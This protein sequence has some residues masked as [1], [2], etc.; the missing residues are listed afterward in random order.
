MELEEIVE[1]AKRGDASAFDR[2]V[3]AHRDMVLGYAR[4]LVRNEQTAE[5]AVQESLVIAHRGLGG[6][7]DSAAFGA[8]LRGIVRRRCVRARGQGTVSLEG[9]EVTDGE[10]ATH[11]IFERI[12]REQIARALGGL[13]PVQHEVVSLYYRD[14]LSQAEIGKRLGLSKATVNMRLHAARARLKRRLVM[15]DDDMRTPKVGRIEQVDGRLV[16]LRFPRDQVPFHFERLDAGGDALRSVRCLPDGLVQAAAVKSNVIW[17]VG[18]EVQ[19]MGEPYLEPLDD[20]VAASI[21]MGTR[22]AGPELMTGIKTI[23]V[24]APLTQGGSVGVFAEWGLGSLVLLPELAKRLD[25]GANRQ[26][27]YA[28]MRPI[29]DEKQWREVNAELAAGSQKIEILYLPIADP[30]AASFVQSLQGLGSKLVLSRSLAEQGIWPCIDPIRSTSTRQS[31]IADEVRKLISGYFS[32]QFGFAERSLDHADWLTVR[33]G[34]LAT[35]FLSQPFHVAEP[36]TRHPGVDADASVAVKTFAGILSG[37]FDD[38][39]KDAFTMTGA[40]PKA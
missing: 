34:R 23:D 31:A 9:L 1:Q 27:V 3:A 7:A 22:K 8:W 10:D 14:E 6:L 17:T 25:T 29:Q 38:R 28:F 16:T 35:R 36:Y 15:N 2:L 30:I 11:G 40:T 4:S 12:S 26:T 37:E 21:A 20:S 13:P 33:R 19:S 32:L 5:D 39:N 24:F 18:Q